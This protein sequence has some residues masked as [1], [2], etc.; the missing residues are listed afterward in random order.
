MAPAVIESSQ[1]ATLRLKVTHRENMF[2]AK[3]LH[4]GRPSCKDN[5]SLLNSART[6]N[7]PENRF[8]FSFLLFSI[9]K[10]ALQVRKRFELTFSGQKFNLAAVQKKQ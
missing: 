8:I 5:L 7:I 3:T 2:Y 10:Y 6:Y 4:H 1:T 9:R